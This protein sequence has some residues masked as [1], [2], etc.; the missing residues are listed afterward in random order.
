MRKTSTAP[1]LASPRPHDLLEM[2]QPERDEQQAR[3]VDVSIVAV[4][5]V[6]LRLVK[7]E[8]AAQPVGGHRAAGSPAENH[9]LFPRHPRASFA[10]A[11]PSQ[12][13]GE[14]TSAPADRKSVV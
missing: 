9:Y 8:T 3:L 7:I 1:K 14:P 4:D 13:H 6:D 5:D 12:L 11:K 10:C 2:R